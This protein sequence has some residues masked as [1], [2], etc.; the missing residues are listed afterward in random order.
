VRPQVIK[1][2]GNAAVS[3]GSRSLGQ[4]HVHRSQKLSGL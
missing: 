3:N 4:L 2:K 1:A